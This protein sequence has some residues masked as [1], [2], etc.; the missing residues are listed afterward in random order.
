MNTTG[1]NVRLLW[2]YGLCKGVVVAFG[3]LC[4][5][6]AMAQRSA[7]QREVVWRAPDYEVSWYEGDLWVQ[8]LNRGQPD[9]SPFRVF[10]AGFWARE[11]G[12]SVRRALAS[13]SIETTKPPA[14]ASPSEFRL[15]IHVEDERKSRITADARFVSNSVQIEA[16][17]RLS[18]REVEGVGRA[19]A[20]F[21]RAPGIPSGPVSAIPNLAQLCRHM[22]VDLVLTDGSRLSLPFA[23]D[24][25]NFIRCTAWVVQGLWTNWV[26]RGSVDRRDA[27]FRYWQYGGTKPVEGFGFLYLLEREQFESRV[28][29]EWS[30]P[31]MSEGSATV[32]R[33]QR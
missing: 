14:R 6:I 11:G 27:W 4:T 30:P 25:T 19:S 33:L 24:S 2:S 7:A 26:V 12:Y 32:P 1:K 3:V 31:A 20:Y 16:R 13:A 5:A 23:E 21:G 8:L 17:Y 10:Y 28:T 18:A 22:T 29:I 9:G 15:R